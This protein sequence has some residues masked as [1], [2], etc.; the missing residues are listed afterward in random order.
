MPNIKKNVLCRIAC[1]LAILPKEIF[2]HCI[3]YKV[4]TVKNEDGQHFNYNNY[5]QSSLGHH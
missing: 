3:P 5:R 1:I 2:Q 4:L